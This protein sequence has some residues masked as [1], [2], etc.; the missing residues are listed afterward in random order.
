VTN[1]ATIGFSRTSLR[2]ANSYHF[3]YIINIPPG[4]NKTPDK[5]FMHLLQRSI[6][7][8]GQTPTAKRVTEGDC[9]RRDRTAVTI[10][11]FVC[12]CVYTRWEWTFRIYFPVRSARDVKTDWFIVC[13]ST[14][15]ALLSYVHLLAVNDLKTS[16]EATDH[17]F[18]SDNFLLL[19]DAQEEERSSHNSRY[20]SW[21]LNFEPHKTKQK[22]CWQQS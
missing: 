18:L 15:F 1:C 9:K 5:I 11:A 17:G 8:D 7:E 14:R 22:C 4:I 16:M 12:N 21:V 13:S 20:P 6:A 2:A 3:T 19:I 10:S